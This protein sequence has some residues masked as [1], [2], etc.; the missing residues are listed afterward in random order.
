[1]RRITAGAQQALYNTAATRQIEQALQASLP[2]H[3]L[4]QRAGL[5]VARLAMAIA[6]HSQRIWL[7][8]GPG[9][10]GGD[11]LEAAVHLKRWGKTPIVTWLGTA[12]T[13]PDDASKSYHRA[14]ESGVEFSEHPPACY[15]LCIDA[16]LGLGGG[17]RP[18]AGKMSDWAMTINASAVPVLAIDLPTGLCADTGKGAKNHVQATHTLS[19]LTLKPGLF[20]AQGR[21]ASGIHWLD[22]LCLAADDKDSFTATAITALLIG[23]PAARPRRHASHKGSYGDVAVIG[24][25]NGMTGAALLAASAALHAGA[26]RVFVGL[27]AKPAITVDARHPELMFRPVDELDITSM[28][29]VCGCGGGDAMTDHLKAILMADAPV[30]IDADAINSIA[31]SPYFQSLLVARR[32]PAMSTVLT[33][34][35]LEAARLLGTSTVEVQGDRLGAA[36]ALATRFGCT[37]VLKG[38][39]TVVASP[40]HTPLI[41]PTGNARLAA[42]GTGDVLAGMIGAGIAEGLTAM[43]AA[44]QAVFQHGLLADRWPSGLPLSASALAQHGAGCQEACENSHFSLPHTC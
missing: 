3:T 32:K 31:K 34:H 41:N 21:D 6:P 35:P 8:C 13:A 2:A 12:T 27:L 40:G 7:A 38:S 19:L 23:A 18:L 15:E 1:M 16:M 9:N 44:T 4:M 10:N 28:I 33:P 24:G 39:G 14:L 29:V 5:A 25:A 42:P 36:T 30:V 17:R 22:D 37:V 43:D 11:G 20:T 26:G